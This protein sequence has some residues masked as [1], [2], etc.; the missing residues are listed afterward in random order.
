LSG[1][2]FPLSCVFSGPLYSLLIWHK[3][4]PDHLADFQNQ[5]SIALQNQLSMAYTIR[6][7]RSS[8]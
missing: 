7:I 4:P 1:R 6:T 8:T 3:P 2:R 5:L